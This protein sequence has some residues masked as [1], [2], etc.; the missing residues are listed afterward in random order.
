MFKM[1]CDKCKELT[2][3]DFNEHDDLHIFSFTDPNGFS[4]EVKVTRVE[5]STEPVHLCSSCAET[6]I[7]VSIAKAGED[8]QKPQFPDSDMNPTYDGFS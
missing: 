2:I 7:S 4:C 8:L 3:L 1:F 5:K 6:M